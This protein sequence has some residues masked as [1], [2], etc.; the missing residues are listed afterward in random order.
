MKRKTFLSILL[1]LTVCAFSSAQTIPVYGIIEKFE[2]NALH[3]LPGHEEWGIEHLRRNAHKSLPASAQ[4]KLPKASSKKLLPE[5]LYNKR[6]NSALICGKVFSCNDCPNLHATI[7]ATATPI[8]DDGVC[9][10]NYHM[11]MPIVDSTAMQKGDSIYFL[12]DF[13]GHMFPMIEIMAYSRDL[14]VAVIKVDTRGTKLD[15]IPFGTPAQTGQHINLISHPKQMP[16]VYTQ[17]FV[18]RNARYDIPGQ[19]AIEHMEITAEF[20]GGSSGG[21]IMD[22][23]GNLVGMVKGTTTLFYED[24]EHNPQ[25]ILRATIPVTTLKSMIN[26]R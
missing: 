11:I 1:L 5:Q 18:T 25:M 12:S 16:Y 17:G 22:D 9:L 15:A 7:T 2:K 3:D 10:V 24:E 19:T 14:D 6:L 23:K 20:A 8:T 4:I 21:P 26:K 13:Y